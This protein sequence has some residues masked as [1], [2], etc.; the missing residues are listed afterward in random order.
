MQPRCVFKPA[1]ALD[2]S[3]L[4]LLSRLTNC[5][6]AVKGGGHAAFGGA[7]SIEGGIT[8]TMEG[9][10]QV[11]VASDKKTVDVGPG[12]RWVD[13]Y[14]ALEPH[15]V[16]VAGGRMAPVG[17]PGLI[18]GGGINFFANKIGWACDNV[19]SFEVVTA[20]GVIVTASP[21]SYSDLYWALRGGGSN[22]GIVTNFKLDAFPLEK[23]WG[24]QRIYSEDKFPAVLD[25]VYRFATTKSS[26]DTDA[27]EIIV[28]NSDILLPAPS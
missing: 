23:M 22:F 10:N 8:V 25:A 20:S 16:G 26:Q 1:K 19:A 27:A 2:V 7:S 13:V 15:G 18:L 21:K 11:S 3:T 24:G 6:F 9:F 17:V 5:P 28:S 4:V 12:N 14:T